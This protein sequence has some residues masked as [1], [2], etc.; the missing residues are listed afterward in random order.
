VEL[1]I[2]LRDLEE[3]RKC[4]EGGQALRL[5]EKLRSWAGNGLPSAV[6]DRLKAGIRGLDR[7]YAG[8]EFCPHRLPTREELSVFRRWAERRHL[9]VTLLTPVM[10]DGEIQ[11]ALALLTALHRDLPDVEVVVNDWGVLHAIREGFPGVRLSAGRVFNKAYKDPRGTRTERMPTENSGMGEVLAYSA[12]QQPELRRIMGEVG[13]SRF[14]RDLLPCELPEDVDSV[15]F[16]SSIY[17]PWGYVTTGRVCWVSTFRREASDRFLPLKACH[18]PCKD[19]SL[20]LAH[21]SCGLEMVQNG[22]TVYYHYSDE[23]LRA[24][25]RA[26]AHS[27]TRLVYQGDLF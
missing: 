19:F 2:H 3:V 6:M 5:F 27:S 7:V 20:S 10:T 18:R 16:A 23:M 11:K 22:N 14:E 21:E 26:A 15:G 24:L 8:D 12:F 13:V 4:E 17:F 1:A 25:L 9:P